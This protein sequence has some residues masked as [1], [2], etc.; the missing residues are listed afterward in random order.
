MPAQM[1]YLRHTCLS[2]FLLMSLGYS[3]AQESQMG[4]LSVFMSPNALI[5]GPR[6][7][8][9][10]RV[11]KEVYVSASYQM[12][13]PNTHIQMTGYSLRA[14]VIKRMDWIEP[15][16]LGFEYM[17]KNQQYSYSDS[18]QI[19][20]NYL[21][22]FDVNKRIECYNFIMTYGGRMGRFYAEGVFGVGIRKRFVLNSMN[23]DEIDALDIETEGSSTFSRHANADRIRF[24]AV[25][26][27]RVG[28]IIAQKQIKTAQ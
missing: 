6:A 25:L 23:Q 4:K 11:F 7:G 12:Y 13:W 16:G 3:N 17:Y 15:M 10:Y 2:V 18:I 8:L 5:E 24:N 28:F 19:A 9:E 14:R 27:A 21:G 20:P 22:V 1:K 26:S